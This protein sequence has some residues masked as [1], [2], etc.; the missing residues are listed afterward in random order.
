ML[1]PLWGCLVAPLLAAGCAQ[2]RGLMAGLAKSPQESGDSGILGAPEA[3]QYLTELYELAAGDPA[4]QVEITADARSAA[5]L[6]PEH[7][8]VFAEA[9][10]HADGRILAYC[11]SGNR[12]SML[13]AAANVALGAPVE[14]VLQQAADAGYELRPAAEF[15]HDLGSS[16]VVE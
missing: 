13:W 10:S 2:T 14:A 11:R 7:V 15:I 3:E 6:T 1:A 8:A 12:S 16:A 5:T 9:L 4:T